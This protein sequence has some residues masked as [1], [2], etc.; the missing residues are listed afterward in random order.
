MVCIALLAL[1][2]AV[3][4][5]AQEVPDQASTTMNSEQA[6]PA[7]ALDEGAAVV[8]AE[9][10]PEENEICIPDEPK[11]VTLAKLTQVY[12]R[13]DVPLGSK[14]STTGETFPIT[15]TEPVMVDDQI[16]IPVGTKGEGEVIHAKKA[17]GSGSGGELIVTAN[18]I[19]LGEQRIP[20]RS[21]ELGVSGKDQMDLAMAT[22]I[23][24]G[25]V[26]FL[27]RGKNIDLPE[28]ALAGAK[29]AQETQILFADSNEAGAGKCTEGT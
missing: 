17:G 10:A 29:L 23:F 7:E 16:V 15:V 26:G 14:T 27:V 9:S 21:M 24:A 13:V 2:T 25:P 11:V 22:G 28:G 19:D 6:G 8:E 18:Y 20:L 1:A 4:V 5:S 3:S 12:I